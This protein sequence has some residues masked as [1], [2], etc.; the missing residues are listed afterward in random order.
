[1]DSRARKVPKHVLAR[2]PELREP[3]LEQAPLG[4]VVDE[5]QRRL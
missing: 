4:V 3:S 5:R 2:Q 1:L